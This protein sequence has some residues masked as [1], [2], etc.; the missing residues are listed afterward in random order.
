MKQILFVALCLVSVSAF[1]QV[2]SLDYYL[3]SSQV[4]THYANSA[5]DSVTGIPLVAPANVVYPSIQGLH[6]DSI[7]IQSAATGDTL[8]ADLYVK[9]TMKGSGVYTWTLV[10]SIKA[11]SFRSTLVSKTAYGGADIVGFRITQRASG[12]SAVAANCKALVRLR[13]YYTVPKGR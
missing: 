4:Y 11:K 13:L 1:S 5:A 2:A 12:A 8:A 10:D 9:A 6:P 7:R 3:P